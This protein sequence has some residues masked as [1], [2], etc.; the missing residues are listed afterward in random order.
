MLAFVSY[1]Y[2]KMQN[3]QFLYQ[4]KGDTYRDNLGMLLGGSQVGSWTDEAFIVIYNL[5]CNILYLMVLLYSKFYVY[6]IEYKMQNIY[7]NYAKQWV[8]HRE[9]SFEGC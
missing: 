7:K 1:V 5:W 6:Y 4:I 8:M 3:I 2:S 9:T